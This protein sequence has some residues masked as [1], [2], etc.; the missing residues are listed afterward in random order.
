M[1]LTESC[2]GRVILV[3]GGGSSG[4]SA[5]ALSLAGGETPQAFVA[6]GQA[7]DEEMAVRIARHQREE[8]HL[9]DHRSAG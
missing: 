1:G 6:T 5:A 4:K 2:T 7:L 8:D 9:G 3:I